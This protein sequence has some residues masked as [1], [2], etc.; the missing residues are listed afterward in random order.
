VAPM[1]EEDLPEDLDLAI[2]EDFEEAAE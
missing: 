2:D 1:D